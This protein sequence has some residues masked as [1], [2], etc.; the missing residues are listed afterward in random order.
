MSSLSISRHF[1]WISLCRLIE[2][3]LKSANNQLRKK[4]CDVLFFLYRSVNPGHTRFHF[5][6]L[7]AEDSAKELREQLIETIR[8]E[9]DRMDG[10]PTKKEI[11]GMRKQEEQEKRLK[12]G[13]EKKFRAIRMY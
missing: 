12:A 10:K 5:D 3:G 7:V 6:N 2:P 1:S 9:F 13:F 4:A 8:D 11:E